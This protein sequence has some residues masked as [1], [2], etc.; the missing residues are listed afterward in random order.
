MGANFGGDIKATLENMEIFTPPE[1]VDP[2]TAKG[3]MDDKDK[4]KLS[5]MPEKR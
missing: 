1:P 5:D 2:V 4:E 3:Y